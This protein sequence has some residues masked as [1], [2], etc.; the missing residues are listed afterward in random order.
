MSLFRPIITSRP[1]AAPAAAANDGPS[2]AHRLNSSMVD[3]YHAAKISLLPNLNESERR[4]LEAL[5]YV[6]FLFIFTAWTVYAYGDQSSFYILERMSS[7]TTE[8]IFATA[9]G[10]QTTF[11]GIAS[12]QLTLSGQTQARHVGRG[13]DSN[14]LYWIFHSFLRCP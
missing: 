2:L 12:V 7:V 10:Q 11:T 9:D 14:C 6:V 1:D 5:T 4:C 3:M 13:T 8:R